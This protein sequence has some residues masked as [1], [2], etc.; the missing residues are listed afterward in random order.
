[1]SSEAD[2]TISKVGMSF[3]D[4]QNV[5]D[6]KYHLQNYF[7]TFTIPVTTLIIILIAIALISV[8]VFDMQIEEGFRKVRGFITKN[9]V[10]YVGIWIMFYLIAL[11]IIVQ[12]VA[13]RSISITKA[14]L[15][16]NGC[17]GKPLE[18]ETVRYRMMYEIARGS[19]NSNTLAV[20][21]LIGITFAMTIMF[22]F[23]ASSENIKY[24]Y[25]LAFTGFVLVFMMFMV[26]YLYLGHYDS[27]PY[28]GYPEQDKY[29]EAYKILTKFMKTLQFYYKNK[30]SLPHQY[31][32]VIDNIIDRI[33]SQ[34]HMKTKRE[35]ATYF[36][37]EPVWKLIEYLSMARG[38]DSNLILE[39]LLCK[40][41]YD[42]K[43]NLFITMILNRY[44]D[45]LSAD[46]SYYTALANAIDNNILVS[47]QVNQPNLTTQSVE[48]TTF[49]NSLTVDE[50]F[51]YVPWGPSPV[52]KGNVMRNYTNYSNSITIADKD[53]C[54][55]LT[56][57]PA[58]P[59][60][61]DERKT[62]PVTDLRLLADN[63]K[64]LSNIQYADPSPY[65]Q[66]HFQ[67]MMIFFFITFGILLFSLFDNIYH[68]GKQVIFILS[69][70]CIVSGIAFLSTMFIFA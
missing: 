21:F 30:L 23:F 10:I 40:N 67:R 53:N 17:D 68:S 9:V 24:K 45:Y 51:Q 47:M 61:A 35:A 25:V 43:I 42:N 54:V 19:G 44:R 26:C 16:Q 33:S 20:S 38:M 64:K 63:V 46:F 18:G 11:L 6:I 41:Y 50:M 5:R 39:P 31:K 65:I 2:D 59:V 15:Y 8:H 48:F 4:L 49:K 69:V 36:S 1:M 62:M 27:N 29:I 3:E 37:N 34:L 22:C 60:F 12:R 66:N 14:Q 28:S 55:Y 70:I 32:R 7:A 58:N 52:N 57:T 13:T 56:S